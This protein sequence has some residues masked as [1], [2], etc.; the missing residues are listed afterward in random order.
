VNQGFIANVGGESV[1]HGQTCRDWTMNTFSCRTL[2]EDV[3]GIFFIETA[4][5]A[6][7]I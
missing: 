6:S 4:H 2:Q 3:H 7:M 5:V 1:P